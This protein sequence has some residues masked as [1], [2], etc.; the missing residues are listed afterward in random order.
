MLPGFKINHTR[1]Y[2]GPEVL[3]LRVHFFKYLVLLTCVVLT[4]ASVAQERQ[5][6]PQG[7]T[8]LPK[9]TS[10]QQRPVGGRQRSQIVDDST[11]Q[12]YGPNTS[13][14]FF[15]NDVFYNR[16][17]QHPI[18]T[19][20]RNFHRWNFVQRYNNLY[21]DLGTVGTAI[22]PIF[23]QSPSVIGARSGFEVYDL[24][25]NSEEVRYF[26]TRS[27]YSNMRVIL[28][29]RGRSMTRVTYSRN[30]SPRW[31]FGV[32]YRG[33][34]IDKQVP[35]RSG[36]GDRA[37][38]SHYYDFFTSFFTKDSTYRIFTNYRRMYH[39]VA[40]S[41]GVRFNA[42][43]DSTFRNFFQENVRVWLTE[44]ESNELRS[45]FHFSHQFQFVR[46]LQVYH[47]L[48]RSRQ[49]YRF[50]DVYITDA[51]FFNG[52]NYPGDTTSDNNKF[53]VVRNELGIKGNLL[54]LFYNG[55][56]AIRDYKMK[57]SRWADP[58][59]DSTGTEIDF[60]EHYA[61]GRMELNLDSIGLVNGW[62][63][64]NNTGELRIEG[65]IRSRWFDASV[66][67]LL[68]KPGFAEQYYYGNHHYWRN[69][70]FNK[71]ESTEVNGFIH[72][73]SKNLQLSPGVTFTRL[74]NYIFYDSANSERAVRPLQSNGSQ[75][76]L[77]PELRLAVKFFRNI[78][79]S[80]QL[81]YTS[82]LKNDDDAI[83]VPEYLS[84]SQLSYSN[85]HFNGNF[86]IQVGLEVHWRSAYFA[87][88]YDPAIRQFFNQDVLKVNDYAL[89]DTFFN[90]K[91]K[92][93]RIFLKWHNFAQ[94]FTKT[95]YFTTP[96]YPG[97]RNI[98]DFGFDWSFYD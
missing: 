10:P 47:T 1:W 92:R 91:I 84:T 27:P 79:L 13:K 25:W 68:Y 17:V 53:K 19:V 88:A 14:Y 69:P 29:G 50:S 37:T 59:N 77:S 98:I 74:G 61:G 56:Y 90:A 23:Y 64:V 57:Y 24:Y 85:I 31:N 7:Q 80:S 6:P 54:K 9:K 51:A 83:R 26:D 81:M 35:V 86:D 18:D 41:G 78:T 32:N 11:T 94:A 45:N 87:Q 76:I 97:Q 66:K 12:I 22:R 75:V 38:R 82:L 46:A 52:N 30:I 8:G 65:N 93:G 21:Q 16:A 73:R 4:T 33:M 20:I 34:F 70:S 60:T 48:D 2:H 49:K 44:A 3:F 43:E 72:Y 89:L 36:K 39:R 62:A 42:P 63:E 67:Q 15:E 58:L 5:P 40:E 28:G 71:I 95:G 96:K 55:Y